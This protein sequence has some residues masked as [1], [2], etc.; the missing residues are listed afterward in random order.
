MSLLKTDS[1]DLSG[2]QRRQAEK[3]LFDCQAAFNL[4]GEKLRQ[5]HL[6]EHDIQ[7]TEPGKVINVKPRWT[8]IKQR[9]HIDKEI[10]GLIDHGLIADTD[11]PYSSPVV[12]VKKGNTG[13]A[14]RMA[15]DYREVNKFC[16]PQ[17]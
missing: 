6:L 15:V 16:L 4:P 17:H 11:S 8:P 10:D 9:P 7:L 14:F 13:K 3:I 1:W 5:T 2:K 12:L